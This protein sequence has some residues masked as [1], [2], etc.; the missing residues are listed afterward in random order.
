MR[1]PKEDGLSRQT[2]PTPQSPQDEE[3]IFR[4][5]LVLQQYPYLRPIA[6]ALSEMT[7][8]DKEWRDAAEDLAN[9]PLS[10]N[11]EVLKAALAKDPDLVTKY[12]F[13][14][15]SAI[16]ENP[17]IRPELKMEII[18]TVFGRRQNPLQTAKGSN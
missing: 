2:D 10:N 13:L 8:T 9:G 16:T 5:K 3:Y 7:A 17:N 6:K 1:S 11:P 14:M 15:T 18:D 4:I 12:K